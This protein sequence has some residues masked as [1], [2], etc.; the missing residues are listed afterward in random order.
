MLQSREADDPFQIH[1]TDEV[2]VEYELESQNQHAVP[3]R[4][5]SFA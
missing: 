2:L 3:Q 5:S 1:R 4:T